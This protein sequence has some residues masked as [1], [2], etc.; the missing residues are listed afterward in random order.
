MVMHGRFELV[1]LA[2]LK[3][4]TIIAT[5]AVIMVVILASFSCKDPNLS[6]DALETSLRRTLDSGTEAAR[7]LAV[8]RLQQVPLP[9]RRELLINAVGAETPL[10]QLEAIKVLVELGEKSAAAAYVQAL[11]SPDA[12]VQLAAAKALL[13]LGHPAVPTIITGLSSL[14][15]AQTRSWCAA[16]LGETGSAELIPQLL[17]LLADPE[18]RVAIAALHAVSKLGSRG[19]EVI[20]SRFETFPARVRAYAAIILARQSPQVFQNLVLGLPQADAQTVIACLE[21][22]PQ[23]TIPEKTSIIARYLESEELAFRRAAV[24]AAVAATA[25]ELELKLEAMAGSDPDPMIRMI[26][27]R[28]LITPIPEDLITDLVR[29][30]PIGE[31]TNE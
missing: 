10:V 7:I 26:A 5:N 23:S 3:R 22:L 12:R 2:I 21:A 28:R 16:L 18:E 17:P 4:S 27:G 24:I 29:G 9:D 19:A 14:H 30:N 11:N 20:G 8:R 13:L 15:S 1:V 25:S 6:S 31:M